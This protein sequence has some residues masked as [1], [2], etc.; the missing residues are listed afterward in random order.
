MFAAVTAGPQLP[1][2]ICGLHCSLQ[3]W[4]QGYQLSQCPIN[5]G[6]ESV[7][8]LTASVIDV[9][10]AAF[11]LEMLPGHP[12]WG[13]FIRIGDKG[14][15]RTRGL[16]PRKVGHASW[17]MQYLAAPLVPKGP[18]L[19]ECLMPLSCLTFD[20]PPLG[21][22]I[23]LRRA[24]SIDH[25]IP[26]EGPANLTARLEPDGIRYAGLTASGPSMGVRRS[27]ARVGLAL[28]RGKEAS[29]NPD[30]STIMFGPNRVCT[31]SR[32]MPFV[33]RTSATS[34][35]RARL[36]CCTMRFVKAYHVSLPPHPA[37]TFPSSTFG[38]FVV[39]KATVRWTARRPPIP[40]DLW[41]AGFPVGRHREVV[42][43][44]SLCLL[45][46]IDR[47]ICLFRAR[48]GRLSPLLTWS[49]ETQLDRCSLHRGT[50]VAKPA[51]VGLAERA[52][53]AKQGQEE[54]YSIHEEPAGSPGSDTL[55]ERNARPRM[56]GQ[57]R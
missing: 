27:W 51:L 34:R 47:Y 14:S 32:R 4:W 7:R 54:P 21:N 44:K 5:Q 53:P 6:S 24:H 25:R 17:P 3:L 35:T 48:A 16:E 43:V 40:S 11:L 56:E 30:I 12:L 23:R 15:N 19:N 31:P 57:A 18:L 26:G 41:S 36:S 28:I 37:I 46:M 13:S 29:G 2:A 10:H 22:P 50:E 52:G 55:K 38:A 42:H 49:A 20:T 33:P 45:Y 8:V 39:S 9:T 1:P